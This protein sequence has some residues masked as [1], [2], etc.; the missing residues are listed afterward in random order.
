M[1]IATSQNANGGTNFIIATKIGD[2]QASF[3]V[4]VNADKTG[5]QISCDSGSLNVNRVGQDIDTT[6]PIEL[7]TDSGEKPIA[8]SLRDIVKNTEVINT[9][10][11]IEIE[12]HAPA[13]GVVA[14]QI[15]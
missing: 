13:P 10:S 15:R 4:A 5:G 11:S 8:F 6:N 1:S 9:D 7:V 14:F 2:L 12:D 3:T